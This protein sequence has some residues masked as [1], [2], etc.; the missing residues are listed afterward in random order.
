MESF[1]EHISDRRLLSFYQKQLTNNT[2]LGPQVRALK[3]QQLCGSKALL[4][5]ARLSAPAVFL[6][7]NGEHGRI[8]GHTT[9]RSAWACPSCTA[10]VMAEKGKQI[11]ALI[12][13]LATWHNLV[14]VMITFTLPHTEK[15]TCKETFQILKDTWRKFSHDSYKTIRDYTIKKGGALSSRVDPTRKAGQVVQYA[16]YQSAY[17]R[18][19][20]ELNIKYTV[21]VYETTWG[22]YGWHPHIHALFWIK[23]SDLQKVANYEQKMLDQWWRKAQIAAEQFWHKKNPDADLT[24]L[25]SLYSDFMKNPNGTH[26]SLYISKNA[27]GTIRQISSSMY[28][29]G[30]GGDKEL[31]NT[32]RKEARNG[33]Y[34][35]HQ[36]IQ[37]AYDAPTPEERDKWLKLYVEY[38]LATRKS[39]RVCY[40][41]GCN[42]IANR[43][44]QS[45][46]YK[47]YLK[48]KA[49][50]TQKPFWEIVCWFS[51]EQ[52]SSITQ[53]NLH[54]KED[55]ISEL[56]TL[57]PKPNAKKHIIEFLLQ[58]DIRLYEYKHPDEQ[59]VECIVNGIDPQTGEILLTA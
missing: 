2:A 30:W 35:P 39:R 13:A 27:D 24:W 47:T 54:I 38:A 17:A 42:A 58:Y 40:S 37:N 52:W 12:D 14:P 57:A 50:A 44:K 59:F 16:H 31:T 22:D 21:R 4:T 32:H 26:R 10:K 19:R 11:G 3:G 1:N 43:W 51:P 5:S 9:C 49:M 46:G 45:E 55:I 29:S 41:P 25:N 33:H 56:L 18:F 7:S 28:I 15:M 8:F 36:I 53:M 23:K 6:L 48:K 20:Q 34:T